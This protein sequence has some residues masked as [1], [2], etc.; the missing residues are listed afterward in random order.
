M[1]IADNNADFLYIFGID[2]KN[3][4][5]MQIWTGYDWQPGH[6]QT[7]PL[8][9]FDGHSNEAVNGLDSTKTEQVVDL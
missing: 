4:L 1:H 6:N 8:G 5:Q 2:E 9:S 3:A 7:W